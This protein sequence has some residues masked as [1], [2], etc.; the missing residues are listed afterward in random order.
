[1][2]LAESDSLAYAYLQEYVYERFDLN[3]PTAGIWTPMDFHTVPEQN[4]GILCL[5]GGA[6]LAL[7]RKKGI[8]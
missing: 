4:S 6:A 7:R 8:V 1:M 3:P 5:L 2:T